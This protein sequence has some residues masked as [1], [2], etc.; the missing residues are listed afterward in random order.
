MRE[1]IHMY[2]SLHVQCLLLCQILAKIGKCRQILI[3]KIVNTKFR[4]NPSGGES[5][6]QMARQRDMK[7][8]IV[9][10]RNHFTK[11]PQNNRKRHHIYFF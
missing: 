10:F 8:L 7:Q 1:I 6:G 3:K 4:E 2:V 9:D 11:A 5:Y